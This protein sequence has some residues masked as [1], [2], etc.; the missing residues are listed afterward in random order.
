M[1]LGQQSSSPCCRRPWPD[2]PHPL[3]PLPPPQT[4]TPM[5]TRAS[6][7]CLFPR[8]STCDEGERSDQVDF[9]SVAELVSVGAQQQNETS[10]PTRLH[11]TPGGE[12]HASS[13]WRTWAELLGVSVVHLYGC[14]LQRIF[15]TA[16]QPVL[17]SLGADAKTVFGER[18]KDDVVVGMHVRGGDLTLDEDL[19][20]DMKAGMAGFE[21]TSDQRRPAS[22]ELERA[23]KWVD[24]LVSRG[25]AVRSVLVAHLEQYQLWQAWHPTGTRTPH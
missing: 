6:G 19:R 14:A 5:P 9:N 10:A 22:L 11:H 3:P 13:V 8:L 1:P 16:S 2:L 7:A 20:A 23:I 18:A 17:D 25:A 4:P 21:M 15:Q 24:S 12:S